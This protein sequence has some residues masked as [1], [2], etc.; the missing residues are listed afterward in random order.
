MNGKQMRML[1]NLGA[2]YVWKVPTK[3]IGQFYPSA[4]HSTIFYCSDGP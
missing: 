1:H 3:F 2:I 4:I